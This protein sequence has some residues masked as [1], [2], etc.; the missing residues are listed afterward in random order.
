MI[1]YGKLWTSNQGALV[2]SRSATFGTPPNPVLAEYGEVFYL[3][4]LVCL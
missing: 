2:L 4:C 3:W 1:I